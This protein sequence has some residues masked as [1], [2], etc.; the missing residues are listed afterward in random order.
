MSQTVEFMLAR[1]FL[2]YHEEMEECLEGMGHEE[3]EEADAG[4]VARVKSGVIAPILAAGDMTRV[5][6]EMRGNYRDWA[7]SLPG[8]KGDLESV[9]FL[10]DR[11]AGALVA[12]LGGRREYLGER[13]LRAMLEGIR[14]R[15]IVRGTR[16]SQTGR[17]GRRS[18]GAGSATSWP[19]TSSAT[20]PSSITWPPAREAGEGSR[21]W[22]PG[23][24]S[25][26]WTHISTPATTGRTR[27]AWR[28]SRNDGDPEFCR[29][30]GVMESGVG[31][32]MVEYELSA[33]P[34]V[35]ISRTDT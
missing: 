8:A 33:S 28:I 17:T 21:P 25:T 6:G 15:G 13:T 12:A 31:A 9:M 19:T 23:D 35:P 22:P 7:R 3:D 11:K 30:R 26:R 14:L 2:L 18:P 10:E 34:S 24:G 20:W 32:V 1:W 29:R 27:Y 16:P 4:E 5:F